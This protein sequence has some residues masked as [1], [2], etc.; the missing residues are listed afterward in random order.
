MS[1][2]WRKAARGRFKHLSKSARRSAMRSARKK[3][4]TQKQYNFR[5]MF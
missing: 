3:H 2:Q 4:K 5:K 1:K